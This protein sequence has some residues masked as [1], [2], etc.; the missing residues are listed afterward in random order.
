M[1]NSL[2]AERAG[3]RE[4]WQR[5]DRSETNQPPSGGIAISWRA[6]VFAPLMLAL[7]VIALWR[8]NAGDEL[9]GL[10]CFGLAISAAMIWVVLAARASAD[11]AS[12]LRQFIPRITLFVVLGSSFL[13]FSR[14]NTDR[15]I[16][17]IEVGFAVIYIVAGYAAIRGL[18]AP[19]KRSR[20]TPIAGGRSAPR[21][22]PRVS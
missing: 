15:R 8:Y 17:A 21:D 22:G 18:D 9:V 12:P 2:L 10:V 14:W 5:M 13:A 1:L 4:Y 11:P 6:W 20:L 3:A 7:F 19:R 16:T